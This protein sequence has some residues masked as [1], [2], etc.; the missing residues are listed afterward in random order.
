MPWPGPSRHWRLWRWPRGGAHPHIVP[1]DGPCDISC[2]P[3]RVPPPVAVSVGTTPEDVT[4]A[5]LAA[6]GAAFG[7]DDRADMQVTTSQA[8]DAVGMQHV[9]LQQLH[10]GVRVT[11]GEMTPL[12][13]PAVIAVHAKTVADLTALDVIPTLPPEEAQAQVHAFIAKRF[14]ISDAVLSEPRLEILNP[15]L[16]QDRQTSSYLA[17]FVQATAPALNEYCWVNAET[18]GLILHIRQLTDALD[19]QIYKGGEST[20]LPD[21][22][23]LRRR[24][25]HGG[26]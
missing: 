7:I 11:A 22:G 23:A 24:P 21:A 26:C 1:S 19:R 13:G 9:R 5:F 6:Y 2:D 18:G 14:G 16:L 8:T 4:Q 12:R 25:A 3:C 10:R 17:W 20:I 15:G